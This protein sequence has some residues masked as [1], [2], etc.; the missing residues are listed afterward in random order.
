MALP[1]I[2]ASLACREQQPTVGALSVSV[3]GAASTSGDGT[4]VLSIRAGETRSVA[5]LVIGPGA[6]GSTFTSSELPA[7]ATL[8]SFLLTLAP[9]EADVGTHPFSIT[10]TALGQSATAALVVEVASAWGTCGPGET[11]GGGNPGVCGSPRWARW[12]SVLGTPADDFTSSLAVD[13]EGH[14]FAA[15]NLG[16]DLFLREYAGD[17]SVLLDRRWPPSATVGV[18]GLAARPG[19]GVVS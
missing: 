12:V 16:T 4:A 8:S 9:S 17:G 7:F 6:D 11:C 5:L 3:P 18:N 19:G 15:G 14:V 2:I 1:L 10:A 13:A